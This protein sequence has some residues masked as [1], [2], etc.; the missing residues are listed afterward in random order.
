MAISFFTINSHKPNEI[1]IHGNSSKVPGL[2]LNVHIYI[3]TKKRNVK[4]TK[5]I[6]ANI[7][8][9]IPSSSSWE[10]LI[11]KTHNS[12]SPH[13]MLKCFEN[14]SSAAEQQL[15]IPTYPKIPSPSAQGWG[16]ANECKGLWRRMSNYA[17]L[18]VAEE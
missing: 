3:L 7:L 8:I 9:T 13:L 15:Q 5:R 4:K 6:E 11:S 12:L 17:H 1:L 10:A 14:S 2:F 16:P 18:K